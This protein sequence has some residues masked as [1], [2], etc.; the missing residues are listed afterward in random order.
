MLGAK[1]IKK[2]E[3]TFLTSSSVTFNKTRPSVQ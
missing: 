3:D 2:T 1:D